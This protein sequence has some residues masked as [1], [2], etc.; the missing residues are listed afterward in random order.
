MEINVQS[1]NKSFGP[2]HVLKNINLQIA[3]AEQVAL[4]GHSGSGK[5]TLL[6][7]L[8]ALD[9]PD[10]GEIFYDQHQLSQLSERELA[11]FRNH[12]IG[13]VFQ[14]HF[15][16]P[17]MNCLDNILLP[18]QIAHDDLQAAEKLALQLADYLGV[19]HCL[20]KMP[21]EVSGGE[22]QRISLIRAVIMKPRVILCDEP[23][24]NLDSQNSQK[25]MSLL[26]QLALEFKATLLVVTHDENIADSLTRKIVIED[27]SI[28]G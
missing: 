20:K 3:S 23:T 24:G 25:V 1:V 7:L 27:G 6:Y 14:F 12:Y 4:V 21:F 11:T 22:Q 9:Q 15:L 10:H 18:V 17:S 19:K 5:S 13:F 2:V 28:I 16:L 26:R 8:G